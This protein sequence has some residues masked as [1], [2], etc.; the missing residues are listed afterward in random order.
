MPIKPSFHRP[1]FQPAPAEQRENAHARGYD[2]TWR[3]VRLAFL[4]EH[5][6]CAFMNHPHAGHECEKAASVVDHIV[7]LPHGP[8]LDWSNLR[9][10]CTTCHAKLTANLTRTGKNEMPRG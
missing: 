6:L 1:R 3:K 10:V 7:P 9:A 5:P 4:R 2:R 8:R